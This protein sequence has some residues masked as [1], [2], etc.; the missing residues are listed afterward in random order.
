M[1]I[2]DLV[3]VLMPIKDQLSEIADSVTLC[4]QV[5]GVIVLI[6]GIIFGSVFILHL[7]RKFK[8]D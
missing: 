1:T 7:L 6:L 8:N 2:E 5:L 3:A 4:W